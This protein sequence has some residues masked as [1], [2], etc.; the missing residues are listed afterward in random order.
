VLFIRN[1]R[2][3]GSIEDVQY[4]EGKR[5]EILDS[6]IALEDLFNNEEISA[7]VYKKKR[8]ELKDQLSNL[9]DQ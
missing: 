6:I 1:R 7:K 4:Q 9:V 8:Q 5:E 2:S 3:S